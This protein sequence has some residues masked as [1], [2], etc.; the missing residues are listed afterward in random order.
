MNPLYIVQIITGQWED[1]W[2]NVL[3]AT[4]DKEKAEK[5]VERFN[6]IINDADKRHRS[7]DINFEDDSN[8]PFWYEYIYYESPRAEVKETKLI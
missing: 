2:I 1:K 3:F 8:L 5:W 7:I 4:L 6:R